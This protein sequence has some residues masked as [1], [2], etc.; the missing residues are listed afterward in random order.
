MI[1]VGLSGSI[2]GLVQWLISA[3]STVRN[4][5]LNCRNINLGQSFGVS[6]VRQSG[7]DFIETIQVLLRESLS[8]FLP[9][10]PRAFS[11]N[12]GRPRNPIPSLRVE[13]GR[14]RSKSFLRGRSFPPS[15]RNRAS[16]LPSSQASLV[17]LAEAAVIH[18]RI[19]V[20]SVWKI[21][22]ALGILHHQR[23][24]RPTRC[25]V[26]PAYYLPSN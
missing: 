26:V 23:G 12:R 16:S 21:R 5:F 13:E 3:V 24:C 20:P 18:I 17:L 19:S 2:S 25:N 22:T 4:A 7:R 6:D 8:W 15:S 14:D 11:T 10:L 1:V 9:A